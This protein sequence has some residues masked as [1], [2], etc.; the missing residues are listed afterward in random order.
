MDFLPSD[1]AI[2]VSTINMLLRDEEFDSLESLCYAFNREPQDIIAYLAQHG[3]V[4]SLEQKQMRQRIQRMITRDSI[5]TAYCFFHQKERVFAHSTMDWQ[6]DDIEYA[7]ASY[8]DEM[9]AELYQLLS[10]GNTNFLRNHATFHQ[11][12]IQAVEELERMCN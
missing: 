10:H 3:Y 2:L 9:N 6:K 12:L 4:Y 5:E 8:V 11:E 1:P 7:I